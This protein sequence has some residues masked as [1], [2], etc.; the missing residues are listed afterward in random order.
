[1]RELRIRAGGPSVDEAL[2]MLEDQLYDNLFANDWTAYN[3]GSQVT[4]EVYFDDDTPDEYLQGTA[5]FFLYELEKSYP[6]FGNR[7][8]YMD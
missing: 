6:G 2:D 8:D 3:S 1:M 5:D 7:I 4:I